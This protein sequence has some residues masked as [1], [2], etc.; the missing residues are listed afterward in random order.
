MPVSAASSMRQS[1]PGASGTRN[2]WFYQLDPDRN[3]GKTNP[4]ND[5]DLADFIKRHKKFANSSWIIC[6]RNI[7]LN[8]SYIYSVVLRVWLSS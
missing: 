2:V 3:L 4:L 6:G 1:R 5:T 8:L 7:R